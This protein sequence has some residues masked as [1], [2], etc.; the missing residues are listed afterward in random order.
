MTENILIIIGLVGTLIIFYFFSIVFR[1]LY[2]LQF[3]I[4]PI[5]ENDNSETSIYRDKAKRLF[6]IRRKIFIRLIVIIVGLWYFYNNVNLMYTALAL[7][8]AIIYTSAT[9]KKIDIEKMY[10]NLFKDY[11]K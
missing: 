7:S 8:F 5:T 11:I 4:L 1:N 6:L 3:K 9:L 2:L 10:D